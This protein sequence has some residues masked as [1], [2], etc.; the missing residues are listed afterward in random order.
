MSRIFRRFGI[1]C[2][3]THTGGGF[4]GQAVCMPNMQ[5]SLTCCPLAGLDLTFKLA[6]PAEDGM[7]F[8]TLCLPLLLALT[9]QPPAHATMSSAPSAMH[10][11]PP[12]KHT[13]L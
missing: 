6:G 8:C 1:Q 4:H 9:A 5:P 7:W 2:Q 11:P 13:A 3:T 12:E 10:A